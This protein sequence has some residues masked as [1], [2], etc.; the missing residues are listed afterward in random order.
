MVVSVVFVFVSV[1][2]V[3]LE[4]V[5]VEFVL[6]VFVSSGFVSVELVSVVLVDF[7]VSNL[8][9]V[10]IASSAAPVGFIHFSVPFLFV[11]Y[12]SPTFL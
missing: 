3:S 6:V 5:F 8:T 12:S 2:F 11:K 7:G 9:L 4:L 1:E 10:L